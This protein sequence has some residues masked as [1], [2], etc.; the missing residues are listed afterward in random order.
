VTTVARG[1]GG[2]DL[3]YT[4]PAFRPQ[5]TGGNSVV[6]P[7][8]GLQPQGGTLA[9]FKDAYGGAEWFQNQDTWMT[10]RHIGPA[11][12]YN[13]T[14]DKA[15]RFKH[16]LENLPNNQIRTTFATPNNGT[17]V[18]D[19]NGQIPQHPVR[20]VFQDDNYDPPKGDNYQANTVT[21]HWD[22]IQVFTEGAAP[23]TTT[24]VPATTTTAATTTAATTTT[25]P[26]TTTTTTAATTT[27]T[28]TLPTTTTTAATTTTTLPACP[29]TF[30]AGEL[31]W[32]QQVNAR[33]DALEG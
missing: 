32:C 15:A 13:T 5:A 18:R 11:N 20:I 29:A 9:G 27:T 4:I 25:Q 19:I 30:N 12:L 23:P 21:W 28:T 16:C 1:T 7:N 8:T 24:T 17:V 10:P 2:F 31:A 6:G 14:T 26:P 3:G 33:L 22:N